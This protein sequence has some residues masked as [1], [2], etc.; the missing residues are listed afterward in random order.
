[1]ALYAGIMAKPSI[2]STTKN[3]T[4]TGTPSAPELTQYENIVDNC[5]ISCNGQTQMI[6][7]LQLNGC[8]IACPISNIRG[9][10]TNN[11]VE[12]Q[13]LNNTGSISQNRY[14]FDGQKN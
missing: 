7:R 8:T 1:M 6:G 2:V 14:Y 5:D 12:N 13:A 4:A 3:P 9:C 10:K 11:N